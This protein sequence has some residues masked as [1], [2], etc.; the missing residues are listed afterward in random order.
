AKKGSIEVTRML[1]EHMA[2]ARITK[3][4]PTNPILIGDNIYSQIWHRGKQLHFALS[5]VIAVDVDGQSD[6]EQ[7]RQS[8]AINGGIV[9]A[10]LK[11]DGK[12]EG[13]ITANTR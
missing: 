11:D 10:Y 1:D 3:D 7:A 9:D 4:D 13:K 6:M 2:E 12:M 5:G 8:I